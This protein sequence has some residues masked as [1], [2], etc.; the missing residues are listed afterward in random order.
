[1][2]CSVVN[3]CFV[4]SSAMGEWEFIYS[5]LLECLPGIGK[6]VHLVLP[7]KLCFTNSVITLKLCIGFTLK[8]KSSV[9]MV[10][11]LFHTQL[12][13]LVIFDLLFSRNGNSWEA[14]VSI[15]SRSSKLYLTRD[16]CD[17]VL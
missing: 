8:E 16:E 9:C 17:L 10:V 15:S 14:V 2:L 6:S 1:M 11:F 7:I 13:F 12:Q 4:V 3:E 5:V